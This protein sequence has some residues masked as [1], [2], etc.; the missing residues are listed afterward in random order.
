MVEQEKTN[1]ISPLAVLIGIATMIVGLLLAIRTEKS[2]WPEFGVA[3][4][5]SISV[6]FFVHWRR[7]RNR[8]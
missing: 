4:I 3:M 8:L 5:L 1:R 7:S 2:P 6:A